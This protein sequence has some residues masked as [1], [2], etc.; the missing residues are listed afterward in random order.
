MSE[1][2]SVESLNSYPPAPISRVLGLQVCASMPSRD[3][4]LKGQLRALQRPRDKV[5]AEDRAPGP[6]LSPWR[7]QCLSR[8]LSRSELYYLITSLSVPSPLLRQRSFDL[9]LGHSRWKIL[10]QFY[11][12]LQLTR[13]SSET[14]FGGIGNGSSFPFSI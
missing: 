13:T 7:L 3:G 10:V 4:L 5:Q 8:C 2:A 9:D 12:L 1:G 14:K 6:I 11:S